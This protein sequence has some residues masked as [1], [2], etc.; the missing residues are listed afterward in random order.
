M[1]GVPGLFGLDNFFPR[2][3]AVFFD[4]SLHPIFQIGKAEKG[5][6]GEEGGSYVKKHGKIYL[7]PHDDQND[8]QNKGK[9]AH[10]SLV[11]VMCFIFNS[12]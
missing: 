6:H 11:L 1:V 7:Y 3:D 8:H 5:P 4:F 2:A 10:T 12:V 9:G